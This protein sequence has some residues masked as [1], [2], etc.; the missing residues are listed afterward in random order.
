ML[1]RKISSLL[2]EIISLSLLRAEDMPICDNGR[3]K[4]SMMVEPED[5]GWTMMVGKKRHSIKHL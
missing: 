2:M 1:R 4:K 3:D 5:A